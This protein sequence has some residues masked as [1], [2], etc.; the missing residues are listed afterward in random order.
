[1]N[2]VPAVAAPGA[3]TR[4]CVAAPVPTVTLLEVPVMLNV[5]VSV[6]VTVWLPTLLKVTGKVPDP[7]VSVLFA[8]STAEPSELVKWTVPVYPEAT[9]LNWSS[10]VTVT[11]VAVPTVALP[12]MD[13]W[14]CVANP[15]PTVIAWEVPVIEAVTV[16]VAVTVWLPS[17]FRVTW[18]SPL[19]FVKVVFAGSTAAPSVL[20][21]CTVP[22]YPGTTLLNWSAANTLTLNA[23]P[24]ITLPGA[25]TAKCVAP[26]TVNSAAGEVTAPC[27]AVMLDVPGVS[28]CARPPALIV[29]TEAVAEAQVTCVVRFCVEESL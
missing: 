3:V 11:L 19:P 16:S 9:L 29:E 21:K 28:P 14:K 4:K 17:V 13:T 7:L 15:D 24:A 1:L 25:D 26:V 23:V 2:G 22:V 20:V 5:A 8:G 6:A 27:L 18:N 10:A 12:G